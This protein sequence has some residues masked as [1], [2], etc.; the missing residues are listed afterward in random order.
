MFG[1]IWVLWRFGEV[2]RYLGKLAKLCRR[3]GNLEKIKGILVV[4]R[5]WRGTCIII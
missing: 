1:I 3:K 5:K 4:L 2:E